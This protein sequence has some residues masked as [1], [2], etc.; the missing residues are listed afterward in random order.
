MYTVL[1]IQQA[2]AS[3][4]SKLTLTAYSAYLQK[5]YGMYIECKR[6]VSKRLLLIR[7]AL[8][9]WDTRPGASNPYS[10]AALTNLIKALNKL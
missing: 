4:D 7:F 1:E 2:Q 6:D 9:K 3:A 8:S 5:L 10:E